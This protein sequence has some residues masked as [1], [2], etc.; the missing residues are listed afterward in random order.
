MFFD[1]WLFTCCHVVL[2]LLGIGLFGFM[3]LDH[4][5]KITGINVRQ[6]GTIAIATTHDTLLGVIV[7]RTREKVTK[8]ELG[9]PDT[10]LLMHS[11]TDT[12]EGSVVLDCDRTGIL[13]D[14]DRDGRDILGVH[15]VAINCVDQDFVEYFQESWGILQVLLLELIAI[16]NPVGF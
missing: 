7:I 12:S 10:F 15:G 8:R 16:E 13:V 4:D 1:F 14:G 5:G 9:V 6:F 3:V 11:N 2:P